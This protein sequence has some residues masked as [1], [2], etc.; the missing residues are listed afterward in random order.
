MSF[1]A[2]HGQ[3]FPSGGE[4]HEGMRKG[5]LRG[6]MIVWEVPEIQWRDPGVSRGIRLESSRAL[7]MHRINVCSGQEMAVEVAVLWS[8]VIEGTGE[9]RS[10]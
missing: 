7:R 10:R 1:D 9:E 6:V 2:P 5:R 8:S 4:Q 3:A